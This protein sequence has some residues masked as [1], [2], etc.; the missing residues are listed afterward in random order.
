M[1]VELV[2]DFQIIGYWVFGVGYAQ[3][4][5][6]FST[7]AREAD[8]GI[9]YGA[10]VLYFAHRDIVVGSSAG[11]GRDKCPLDEGVAVDVIGHFGF[12]TA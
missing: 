7:F 12:D 9:A 8:E 6:H 3:A 11:H 4:V 10:F 1:R 5:P 2:D